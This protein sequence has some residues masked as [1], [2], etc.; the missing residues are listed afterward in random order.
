MKESERKL[1]IQDIN[2]ILA[3]IEKIDRQ[4]GAIDKGSI[5][6]Q[7]G[8]PRTDLIKSQLLLIK[9]TAGRIK[10]RVEPSTE[11]VISPTFLQDRE[12]SGE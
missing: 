9:I 1:Q 12:S 2:D 11:E 4:F 3:C 10:E 6:I 5:V 8:V 7:G